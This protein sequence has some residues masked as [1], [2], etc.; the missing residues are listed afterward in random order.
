MAFL[1]TTF[2]MAILIALFLV[3]G[4]ALAGIAGM[5]Y[6]LGFAVVLNLF[7][8]WFSDGIVLRMY[9]AKPLKDAKI[10]DMIEDL[11]KKAG[12]P[13]PRTYFV[14]T[15][16]P[17]AFATG[18]SPGHSAVA[19]TRG[20]V[21]KLND[22]EIRGVLAHEI[23]HIKHRDTLVSTM[24]AVIAGAISWLGYIFLF[25]D[26]DNRNALGILLAFILVPIAASL[27]RLAITRTREYHADTGGA[28]IDDPLALASAL[29]KISDYAKHV[30][31]RGNPSTAHM[32]IVNPFSGQS[33]INL[34]STHPPAEE[35]VRRLR[36]MSKK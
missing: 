26:R 34:F 7:A 20:L 21:D 23:S 4:Y 12:I 8:F 2:L 3:I 28:K 9:R 32:W 13:S 5:T 33:L 30:R 36:E 1:R 6:A 18:R 17:N 27:I 31:L 10:N 35:R 22:K 11:A 24:A 15:D 16:V 25:G 14:D 19:V 29:E